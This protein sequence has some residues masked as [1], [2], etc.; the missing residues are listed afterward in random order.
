MS[1]ILDALKKL[2]HN[3]KRGEVPDLTTVHLQDH[4]PPKKRST[5]PYLLLAAL[6]LN[7]GILTAWLRPWE[8]KD[9]ITLQPDMNGTEEIAIALP[10]KDKA[11]ETN[12]M[13]AE[14]L[15]EN[16]K[17]AVNT[18]EVDKKVKEIISETIVEP[19]TL[20][21]QEKPA[22]KSN[23]EVIASIGLDPTPE[24]LDILRDKIEEE[25]D[26]IIK[27]PVEEVIKPLEPDVVEPENKGSF[28]EFSQL[29]EKVRK[30][31]PDITINGHIYSD[32]KAARIATI[33]GYVTREG[34][35]VSSGLILEEITTAGV[36][37]SFKEYR[38]R[39]R[40]F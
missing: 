25:R 33:N 18:A 13:K 32:I 6:I 12:D 16:K 15:I 24:E 37:F 30:E 4:E 29:P 9:V 10:V 28:I 27:M 21:E 14:Y 38:F 19:E 11:D 7:A 23:E 5:W 17:A 36:I 26:I 35:K 2:E 40:A 22:V 3:R 31:L 1:F 20:I 39:M 8:E 34:D